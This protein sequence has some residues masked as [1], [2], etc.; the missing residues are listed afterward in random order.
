MFP[1]LCGGVPPT[2]RRARG[3]IWHPCAVTLSENAATE[4]L[5]NPLLNFC[6]A[7]S[8]RELCFFW[9]M[10]AEERKMGIRSN[11]TESALAL[12][13]TR[14]RNIVRGTSKNTQEHAH[15]IF[16][17]QGSAENI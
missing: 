15:V 3:I 11:A 13:V 6:L 4:F 16:P 14:I 7:K 8:S 17:Q 2:V 9:H 12:G 10:H 5:K 1:K